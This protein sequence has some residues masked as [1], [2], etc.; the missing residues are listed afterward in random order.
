MLGL[1]I[2]P[3][4]PPAAAAQQR[5]HPRAEIPGFDFRRDG[6]WRRQARQIRANRARLLDRRQFG[7]LNAPIAGA[8]GAPLAGGAPSPAAAAVSGVLRVPAILFRYRDT[9]PSQLR[10]AAQY[11]SA[12]FAATPPAGRPYTYR[13]LY[14]E[15]SNGLLSIQGKT[16]GYAALDDDEAAYTGGTS[17]R[18]QL[19]NPY[20][21]T[22]CNG[23]F[24][25]SAVRVMQAGL[26]LALS[27]LDRSVDWTHYDSDADGHVDL[28][29]F[30]PPTIG[31]ECGPSTNPN[32][33][34]WA[35]RFVLFPSY[36][37]HSSLPSG[38]R[39]VVSDYILQSGVG[40]ASGCDATQIMPIGTVAHETGHALGLPD[41]YDVADSSEGIGHWGLMG[42]GNHASPLSPS[43]MEAWSLNELGWVTVVPLPDAGAHSLGAAPISD[44]AFYLPVLGPNPR[45]EYFLL[46][47]RQRV[48]SDSAMIRMHCEEWY[49]SPSPPASCGGGLILWHIDSTQ[50]A[51]GRLGSGVNSGPIHGVALVQADGRR[52]LD[53][54]F[55]SPGSNRG[56]AGD[57]Y[58]GE[59]GNV[60]FSA[61]TVPAAVRNS[62]GLPAGVLIDQIARLA[63]NV[64]S[65][66]VGYPVWVVRALD[67]AAVIQFDAASY[68][69]FRG[70]LDEGSIHTVSVA[71]T[72]YTAGGRTRHVFVSWSD[73][74]SRSHSYTAG[75]SPETLTV[76]L[77][78]AHQLV[79]SGTSG[80]MITSGNPADTSRAF[81]AE[82]TPVTLTAAGAAQPFLSWSGDTVSQHAQITLPMGR[83][84]TVRAVF[85]APLNTADVVAQL[86][87]G[88]SPLTSQQLLD[89][90][91]LGNA[92]GG[93][94]V[95]DFLAWVQATGAPLAAEQ[96]GRAGAS[97]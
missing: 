57:P 21:S 76:T 32:N 16:F 73:G 96:R 82:G 69:V 60:V 1:C 31:G 81:V 38:Q 10:T 39:I 42:A 43:R 35:H 37:T 12:L 78:R 15:M 27:K 97:R 95:G 93:F 63:A 64:M 71:D 77:A 4:A 89:L 22:N 83:P 46:E 3:W 9:P 79:Y 59:T 18:C 17:P 45:G 44:T 51:R 30:L 85:L 25:D 86:L 66:R 24:S 54:S 70:I 94:D 34:L 62:D 40:G 2:V 56:D 75:A 53:V 68:H 61:T 84:Y 19:A 55:T 48:H 20:G 92:N 36:V 87:D 23:L 72:Q 14:E 33:H 88:V 28:V 8:A 91:Q 58:P 29:L 6:G 80:G 41:L 50:V 5:P 47:N 74:G 11:N 90:D 65:F 26:R 67:S 49:G 13:S 7:A 52:N